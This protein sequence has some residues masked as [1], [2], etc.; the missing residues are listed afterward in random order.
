MTTLK[1]IGNHRVEELDYRIRVPN[2]VEIL[3]YQSE[4]VGDAVF[5]FL[6]KCGGEAM[7][8]VFLE[9]RRLE[10]RTN[11]PVTQLHQRTVRVE[12]ISRIQAPRLPEQLCRQRV[13]A[14]SPARAAAR[15]VP[16]AGRERDIS[17]M[18]L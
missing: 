13:G 9:L 10:S 8:I 1:Q 17:V 16:L 12:S 2:L 4:V 15:L 3:K 14:E 11:R 5:E 7:W 18:Q 6:D